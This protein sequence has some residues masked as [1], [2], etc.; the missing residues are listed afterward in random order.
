MNPLTRAEE[1]EGHRLEA[2]EDDRESLSDF[3]TRMAPDHPPP[4]HLSPLIAL[5]ERARHEP[6]RAV[7]AMPPGHIKT[8]TLQNAFAWW[9]SDSPADTHAYV[10][11]NDQQALSKSGPT[12]AIARRAGVQL[13]DDST[14]KS[15]WRTVEGGGLLATGI[16]GGL[17]GQRVTGLMVIDDPIKNAE[18]A[19]SKFIR[20]G[21]WEWF[22]SVA[23]TRLE[24]ASVIVVMTRWHEDDLAG[25]LAKQGWE[26]LN[27][28]AIA[29]KNDPLGREEGEALWPE[30]YPLRCDNPSK[31]THALHLES[32]K[33]AVG[34]YVFAA[35]YQGRPRPRGHTL[36]GPAHYYDPQQVNWE[37][38][39]SHIGADPAA[40]ERTSADY[41]A[42]V[43][44]RF[45]GRDPDTA[46]MYIREVY[47]EQ[48]SVPTFCLELRAFQ[49][50]ND[51]A[52]A[53]V[54]GAG[55]GKAVV[56]VIRSVDP[57][58][59]VHEVPT[60]GDKFQRAQ[61]FA[62]AWND[63]RV[64][65]PLGNPPWLEKFLDQL[66]EVTMVNDAHEDMAD[67]GAHCWN[68]AVAGMAS[69]F[70]AFGSTAPT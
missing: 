18:E 13:R 52:D 64:L 55:I 17:T 23:M 48:V 10:S 49:A 27:L 16:G 54:E 39:R 38:C 44:A 60:K 32:Q 21:Q 43:A 69:I 30:S 19:G 45:R 5:L 35:L 46:I 15:E 50:R 66:G 11:Y 31:C 28:P 70:D 26:V 51:S 58:A 47:N 63:S 9:L 37:G 25:R 67:A 20:D 56:Q 14:S 12:R 6:V 4:R 59:R 29:E 34:E 33:A 36:F 42:A 1:N 24:G 68:D 62:A 65:V 8:T 57:N 3:I 61:G 2:I 22:T 53:G 41:S 7:V 40:S